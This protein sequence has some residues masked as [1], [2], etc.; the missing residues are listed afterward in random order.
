MRK[1][2]LSLLTFAAV[3][4]TVAHTATAEIAWQTNLRTAHAQA[5]AEGKL[6]LLHFYAD[7]CTWCDKL[8]VGSFLAP[9]VAGET[10]SKHFVPVKVHEGK[11]PK[12]T[13]MFKVSRF[14]TDVIVTT[15]GQTLSHS[16]SPQDPA[17]YVAMLVQT[18]PTDKTQVAAKPTPQV[19]RPRRLAPPAPSRE[20]CPTTPDQ[21][22]R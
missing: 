3:T 21:P 20:A 14:P 4:M 5:E 12:L 9:Q 7:N 15:K 13:E 18:V 2:A 8:E 1:A 22:H 11:N 6:L 17:R 10:I 19:C 16:I